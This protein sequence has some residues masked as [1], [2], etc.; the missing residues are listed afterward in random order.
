MSI[1][2][3]HNNFSGN[4]SSDLYGVPRITGSTGFSFIEILIVLAI[5]A[6]IATLVLRQ[7][8]TAI[9]SK[10]NNDILSYIREV[11]A[12]QRSHMALYGGVG[13]QSALVENGFLGDEWADLDSAGESS[14]ISALGNVAIGVSEAS[15]AGYDYALTLAILDG[16]VQEK[17][18]TANQIS[19]ALGGHDN[20]CHG[21][22]LVG[23]AIVCDS[24]GGAWTQTDVVPGWD[25]VNWYYLQ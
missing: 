1:S 19:M 8:D 2:N 3:R 7:S 16:T 14:T 20:N 12:A 9:D 22:T 6:G 17:L 25:L 5:V 24:V 15:V 13:R 10:I 11:Q 4:D 21:V 18:Q 23:Q